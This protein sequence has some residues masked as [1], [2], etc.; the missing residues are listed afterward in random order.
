MGWKKV[1]FI[2]WNA[3]ASREAYEVVKK[4]FGEANVVEAMFPNVGTSDYSP[5]LTKMAASPADG[6]FAAA[7]G[8]DASRIV[9]QYAD[10]GLD[11][12]MPLFGMA[13]F[14]SEELLS[15][16][17]EASVGVLSAYT[18]CGTLDTPENK[19]FV[20]NYR[21]GYKG[22]PG[23]YQYM[24]YMAA[25]MAAQAIKEIG[26][27]V[28]DKDAFIAALRKVKINGPM[29][30]ASF[31][32]SQG[33]VGDFYVLKVEKSPSGQLQNRCVERVPQV[34]DPYSMFP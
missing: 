30:M 7:W 28:E 11:K 9:Q 23:S 18:Y 32:E 12:K 24:G 6:V 31:D 19:E 14:T 16:M 20:E 17:P 13:S 1:Y 8:A 5:Y 33:M 25:K 27:R 15:D 10:Y 29:G 3:P 22:S 21:S 34:K 26:G 2:G 4:V